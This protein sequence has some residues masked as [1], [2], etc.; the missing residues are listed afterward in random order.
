MPLSSSSIRLA[1]T[2]VMGR[3]YSLS[4]DCS[5][6]SSLLLTLVHACARK[7]EG[8]IS[9]PLFSLSCNENHF[10][11]TP[12]SFTFSHDRNFPSRVSS[13]T[14]L[15]FS[16]S[17]LPRS[18]SLSLLS[19]FLSSLPLPHFLHFSLSLSIALSIP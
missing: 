15:V 2:C 14:C 19:H 12:L 11:H 18:L 6:S 17:S 16:S 13:R 7:G 3:N 9:F 5:P 8:E 4:R 10:H 1:H